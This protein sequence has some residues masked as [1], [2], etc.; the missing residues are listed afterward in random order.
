MTP[1]Q[2]GGGDSVGREGRVASGPSEAPRGGP[3]WARASGSFGGERGA[4]SS[5]GPVGEGPAGSKARS[6][7]E[8]SQ[9]APLGRNGLSVGRVVVVVVCVPAHGPPGARGSRRGRD[10]ALLPSSGSSA[11]RRALEPQRAF[12]PP[13]SPPA[14]PQRCQPT[15]V[16]GVL[17]Q[18]P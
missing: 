13:V 5:R 17:H 9:G 16:R 12:F 14:T 10:P 15:P 11:G 3:D 4:G 6:R 18:R 2:R 7:S 1:R 8:A